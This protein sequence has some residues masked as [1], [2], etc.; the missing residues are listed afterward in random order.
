M[1]FFR[2]RLARLDPCC[3]DLSLV[4]SICP[5]L[6]RFLCV[7]S[8]VDFSLAA[9][10]ARSNGRACLALSLPFLS[11]SFFLF[12][13]PS[14][15]FL[16]LCMGRGDV[17]GVW[18]GV[19]VGGGVACGRGA[20]LVKRCLSTLPALCPF[21]P[22]FLLVNMPRNLFHVLCTGTGIVRCAMTSWG[23]SGR[24]GSVWAK[25]EC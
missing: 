2:T 5:L 6:A 25:C 13:V 1:A 4:A 20:W 7:I 18:H 10:C 8:P 9:P 16:M 21:V 22:L 3:F 15:L 24:G 12:G 11:L 14:F 23:W 19:G 17:R